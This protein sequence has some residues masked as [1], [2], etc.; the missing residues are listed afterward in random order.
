MQKKFLTSREAAELL[1][2]KE[3]TMEV[4]RCHGKGPRFH[5]A[6]RRVLYALEDIEA[7]VGRS[8]GSTSEQAA[9]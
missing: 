6:G 1:C 8:F 5:R 7:F 4:W 9:S 2:L 3:S